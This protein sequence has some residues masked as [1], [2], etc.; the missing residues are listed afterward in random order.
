MHA[1]YFVVDERSDGELFEDGYKSFE[2]L[3]V[4]LIVA[5]QSQLR[6]AL[7]LKQRAVEAINVS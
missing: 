4:F 6:L 7:P 5:L 2:E 3:A 1:K